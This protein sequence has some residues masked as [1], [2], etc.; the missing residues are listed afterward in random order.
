MEKCRERL[1]AIWLPTRAKPGG[2]PHD[3]KYYMEKSL[4]DI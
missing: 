4:E 3:H 1:F 2:Q